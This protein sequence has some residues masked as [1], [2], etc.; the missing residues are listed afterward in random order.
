M[1]AQPSSRDAS[2]ESTTDPILDE[3]A[4]LKQKQDSAASASKK[5]PADKRSKASADGTNDASETQ[6]KR[7]S[8]RHVA[9]S[10]QEQDEDPEPKHIEKAPLVSKNGKAEDVEMEQP[11]KAG[12]RDPIGGYKTNPP[13]EGRAVRVYADGVFDL[14]HLG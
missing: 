4:A 11:Q 1:P 14:F 8:S 7:R 2:D 12:R 3:V 10:S 13:P 5:A 6:Q 9:H